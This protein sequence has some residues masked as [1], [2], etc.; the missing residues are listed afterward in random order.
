[1]SQSLVGFLASITSCNDDYGVWVKIT[2]QNDYKVERIASTVGTKSE[3]DYV[4]IGALK[5]LNFA[6]VPYKDRFF[7]YFEA[8]ENLVVYQGKILKVNP[9]EL[10]IKIQSRQIDCDFRKFILAEVRELKNQIAFFNSRS[11]VTNDLPKIL[12]SAK[13]QEPWNQ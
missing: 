7:S 1:M 10:F 12:I 3:D 11:F 5:A 9:E 6:N 2:D 8:R 13:Q 4:F